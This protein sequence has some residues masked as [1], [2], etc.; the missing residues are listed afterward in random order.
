VEGLFE[1]A[2]GL[3][4]SVRGQG[5]SYTRWGLAATGLIQ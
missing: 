1:D 4:F 5:F 3:S 2:Q